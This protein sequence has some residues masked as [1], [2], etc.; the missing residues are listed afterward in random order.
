MYLAPMSPVFVMTNLR[1]EL[2]LRVTAP[3]GIVSQSS[4][5]SVAW[6]QPLTANRGPLGTPSTSIITFNKH[7]QQKEFIQTVCKNFEKTDKNSIDN[8]EQNMLMNNLHLKGFKMQLMTYAWRVRSIVIV[9]SAY[10]SNTV[11]VNLLIRIRRL[12]VIRIFVSI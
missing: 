12:R 6:Q 7:I 9:H 10:K 1:F 2:L 8:T 3:K 4:T 5:T 11:V